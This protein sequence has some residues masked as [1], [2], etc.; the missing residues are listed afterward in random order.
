M[1]WKSPRNKLVQ[2]LI[3]STVPTSAV[4]PPAS[5]FFSFSL[6]LSKNDKYKC[7]L[8]CNYKAKDLHPEDFPIQA[9]SLYLDCYKVVTL[10]SF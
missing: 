9:L 5:V 1:F 6:P 2:I 8:S 10:D 7:R 3:Y 4:P